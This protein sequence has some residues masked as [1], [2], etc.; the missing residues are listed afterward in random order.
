MVFVSEEPGPHDDQ[1]GQPLEMLQGSSRLAPSGSSSSIHGNDFNL[2]RIDSEGDSDLDDL[3]LRSL[4]NNLSANYSE[5]NGLQR[6]CEQ[7]DT[8]SN[9]HHDLSH[10]LFM[11]PVDVDFAE[12]TIVAPV[13]LPEGSI[14]R[15]YMGRHRI[16]VVE[17]VSKVSFEICLSF[18][19][20]QFIVCVG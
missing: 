8:S 2:F 19:Y 13:D 12:A 6:D 14:L 20:L 16:L 5:R 15:V 4:S 17:V 10:D 7:D 9:S 3:D 18:S 1:K 11:T